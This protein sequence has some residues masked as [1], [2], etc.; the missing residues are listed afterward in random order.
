VPVEL[1]LYPPWRRNSDPIGESDP[2]TPPLLFHTKVPI[3]GIGVVH[4]ITEVSAEDPFYAFSDVTLQRY[5]RERLM[6]AI[7]VT[8]SVCET[9]FALSMHGHWC[10]LERLVKCAHGDYDALRGLDIDLEIDADECDDDD[11]SQIYEPGLAP[12]ADALT[13]RAESRFVRL[14]AL[15]PFE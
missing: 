4:V 6:D 8:G 14:P 15:E 5:S 11:A 10:E 3:E 1:T 12:R 7:A 13:A 9:P 2:G